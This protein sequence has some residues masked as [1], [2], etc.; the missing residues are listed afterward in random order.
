MEAAFAGLDWDARQPSPGPSP[1]R[2]NNPI[3]LSAQGLI[4]LAEPT[5]VWPN[6]LGRVGPAKPDL[7]RAFSSSVRQG[8]GVLG[9]VGLGL[10]RAQ[11]AMPLP[12][13]ASA[14]NAATAA[15]RPRPTDATPCFAGTRMPKLSP[16]PLLLVLLALL[17][18]LAALG[19]AQGAGAW[20]EAPEVLGCPSR[21]AL[22]LQ[23]HRPTAPSLCRDLPLHQHRLPRLHGRLLL[24]RLPAGHH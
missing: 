20:Q 7:H 8:M 3:V 2:A 17:A 19:S 12:P 15:T 10:A 6:P 14:A 13:L 1:G 21:L 23:A 22:R 9:P 5:Q 16:L 4:R 24:H 18:L 11:A